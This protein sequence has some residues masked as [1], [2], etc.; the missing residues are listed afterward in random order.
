MAEETKRKISTSDV[1]LMLGVLIM[2]AFR[3]NGSEIWEQI[4]FLCGQLLFIA[5]CVM[6]IIKLARS[7]STAL[8]VFYSI[9]AA[10]TFIAFVGLLIRFFITL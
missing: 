1:L 5:S 8:L 2:A 4:L 3:F 10:L 7:K 9:I 6:I